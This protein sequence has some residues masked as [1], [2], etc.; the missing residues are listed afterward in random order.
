MKFLIYEAYKYFLYT[1]RYKS[2]V[3]ISHNFE[4]Q[5]GFIASQ[6]PAILN[7]RERIKQIYAVP[8]SVQLLAGVPH[9]RSLA[10]G[11]P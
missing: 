3:K 9:G 5:S 1:L 10:L 4:E 6:N 8:F 2:R 7:N 11:L